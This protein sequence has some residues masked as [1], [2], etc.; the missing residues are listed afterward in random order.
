MADT[1]YVEIALGHPKNR[2]VVIPLPELHKHIIDGQPLFRSYYSFDEELVEHFKVRKTIKNYHGKYYLDRIIFDI[3][4]G[5]ENSENCL[6]ISKQFLNSLIRTLESAGVESVENYIQPWFSG[7]GYHYSIPNVFGFVPSNKLPQT[8]KRTLEE[9]FPEADHIYDGARLIRVGFTLNEKSK[10]YKV[11]LDIPEVL[12]GTAEEIEMLAT[13]PKERPAP[14]PLLKPEKFL[15][16]V[17]PEKVEKEVVVNEFN[18]SAVVTCIQK[19][20][21]EGDVK[22]SRHTKAL[23]IASYLLRNGIPIDASKVMIQ[24]WATS[25]DPAEV[26]RIVD[27]TYRGVYRY[28]CFD[29]IMDKYCDIKCIYYPMKEKRQDM[30]MPVMSA[31][32][33]E[34][35]FRERIRNLDKLPRMNLSDIYLLEQDFWINP[36]EL[37]IVIGD[38][39]MG[40]TAWVQNLVVENKSR[41]LWLSL[42]MPVELMYRRFLQIARGE[43]KHEIDEHYKVSSNAWSK[44]I[45]H[46]NCVTIPPKIEQIRRLVA[47]TQPNILVLDTIDCV[48]VSKYIHDSMFKMDEIIGEIREIATTQQIIVIG[49]SHTTKADSRTGALDVHSGKHSS[50]IAQKADQVIAVE[51]FRNSIARK[52]TSKK[53]RD[54][55]GLKIACRFIPETFRFKQ[56]TNGGQSNE[57]R[58]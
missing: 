35:K 43:T 40:K 31:S 24:H 33:M 14:I 28:G 18:P 32:D 20:Y 53:D 22:G 23:R 34:T 3:D 39:G 10:L 38:T 27:D 21:A 1:K 16:I 12:F 50:S 11:P 26:S 7:R 5:S 55:N 41:T 46:I 2:G 45:E 48:K 4:K 47:E 49:V 44:L 36:G 30:L 6:E 51:G 54:G 58:R 56:I 8:V 13:K 19:M 9:Y 42:E 15:D 57:E 37:V 52:I 29:P 17:E 25:L